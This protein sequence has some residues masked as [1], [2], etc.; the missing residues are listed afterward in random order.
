MEMERSLIWTMIRDES[1]P[2]TSTASMP[3]A[4]AAMNRLS[5]AMKSMPE[6]GQSLLKFPAR[7]R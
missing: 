1:T 3:D 4:A 5:K 6:S 7:N 2:V